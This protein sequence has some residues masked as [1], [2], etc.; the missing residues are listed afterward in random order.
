MVWL[1]RYFLQLLALWVLLEGQMLDALQVLP[2][3]WRELGAWKYVGSNTQ[4]KLQ[5]IGSL[6]Y[7]KMKNWM[8]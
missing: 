2:T 4:T 6:E 8:P 3:F 7:L 1:F 5:T